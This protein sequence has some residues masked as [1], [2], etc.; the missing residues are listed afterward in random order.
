[1]LGRLEMDVDECI[2]AYEELMKAV[3]KEALILTL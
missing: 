3:F 1:M 2:M